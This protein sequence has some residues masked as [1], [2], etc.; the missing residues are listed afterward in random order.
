MYQNINNC[1]TRASIKSLYFI[2][3]GGGDLKLWALFV[4]HRWSLNRGPKYKNIDQG[5]I[6]SHKTGCCLI[7]VDNMTG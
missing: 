1:V 4:L 5:L 7:E 6:R 2:F 3:W